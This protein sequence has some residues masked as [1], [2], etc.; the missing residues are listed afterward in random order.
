M[1]KDMIT[2]RISKEEKKDVNELAVKEG[3]NTVSGFIMW[4]FRQYKDGKLRR[5]K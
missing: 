2:I 3:H 1:K 4:L 5:V